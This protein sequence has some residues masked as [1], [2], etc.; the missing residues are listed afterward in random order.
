MKISYLTSLLV[1][2]AFLTFINGCME[3]PLQA[4]LDD[5]NLFLDTL[6]LYDIEGVTYQIPPSI[7]SKTRLSLGHDDGF[8]YKAVLLK[9]SFIS[10]QSIQWVLASFIDTNII[11]DSAFFTLHLAIDTLIN[12]ASFSLFSFPNVTDSVF[13]ESKSHYL[14]FTDSEISSGHYVASA[15]EEEYE[16]IVDSVANS[17]FRVR[18]NVEDML[19]STFLDTSLNYTLMLILD[20]DDDE[21]HS[22][23]SRE[24][25]SSENTTPALDIYFRQFIYPDSADTSFDVLTDTLHRSFNV[26]NDLSI[27][28]PPEISD[29]DSSF[30]SISRGKGLRSLI[31]LDFLD[32][33]ILPKQTTFDKAE[34]TF[35]VVPDTTITTF[36]IIAIPLQ[37]TVELIGFEYFDEDNF[38]SYNYLTVSGTVSDDKVVL[39]IKRFMQDHYFDHV[40]NLGIKLYSSVNNDIH[41]TVHLYSTD[42]DSLYPKLF[43]QYVAP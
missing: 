28:V 15:W 22:F 6:H 17:V 1:T 27:L 21:L 16:F 40:N 31:S 25:F 3:E 38:D 29:E 32:S 19:D 13:S 36:S 9:T 14:N 12:P 35:Y 39:N 20:E 10:A 34:L 26:I 41:S 8:E 23:Y 33:L 24:Y 7:G 37:D 11:I 42:H 43:I 5:A 30:I 2:G 4:N 18:F